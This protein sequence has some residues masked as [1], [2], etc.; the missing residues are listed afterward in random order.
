LAMIGFSVCMKKFSI[1]KNFQLYNS[2][3][4][5]YN[6]IIFLQCKNVQVYYNAG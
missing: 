2:I 3:A 4:D 1:C 6:K 5:F